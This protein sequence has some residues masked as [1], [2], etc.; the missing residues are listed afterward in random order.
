MPRRG[1]VVAPIGD[2]AI[3][4]PKHAADTD[5]TQYVS[6]V[7]MPAVDEHLGAIT[8]SIDR[9]LSEVWTGYTHFADGDV[10]F[11]KITPCME[12]G[13]AAIAT[14]LTNGLACGSTEFYVARPSEGLA[15][16]YLWRFLRQSS[17]RQEAEIHMTGAVGQRRVP[18]DYLEQYSL[19]LPPAA[20]Q[21]R[22]VAK[23]DALTV[24]I[25]RARAELDRV[26]ALA[27][28]LRDTS[29]T[30]A[31]EGELTK[32]IG[33][34][35][36]DWRIVPF[37][38]AASIASNLVDPL[39]I[40]DLPHIA[41][42]HIASGIPHLLPYKTIS[43]DQVISS[44]HRFFAG[45]IIY[46]KIRPY[47]RKVILVDFDGACSAD[48]YPIEARCNSRYLMYWM[49]SPQF[50][51]LASQ[52]EGRTVLP[53]INQNALNSIPT[54][55][56]PP[57]V[58]LAIAEKLDIIFARADRLEA[59]ASRARALLDRLEAAILAKAF[60][61]E[62]VPQDPNDEPAGVLLDRIRAERAAAPKAKRGRRAAAG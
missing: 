59:E 15:S 49:L 8:T 7:P 38:E 31:F 35:Q 45:Q 56:A 30:A 14:N 43:E 2:V 21:R 32:G 18:R 5:R 37:Y 3:I 29:L 24:R 12:N 58:Q 53:K 57:D 27:R 40:P 22:I 41:P 17:F 50:T 62:L 26:P 11:A 25:D 39:S 19:P 1:W 9:A 16:E 4:N 6:F 44:K 36:S 54:P 55:L 46:S 10:I 61:G 20:E 48:M 47:L 34:H 28:H 33:F 42:N 13:K 51:W 23:L 60:R 52:H